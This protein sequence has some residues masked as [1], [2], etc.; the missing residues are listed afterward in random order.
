MTLLADIDHDFIQ[1]KSPKKYDVAYIA[2]LLYKA[3][4]FVVDFQDLKLVKVKHLSDI[5][6]LYFKLS[7]RQIKQFLDLESQVISIVNSH[8]D[9]WFNRRMDE[10][11]IE[12]FY[13]SCISIDK[14]HGRVFKV[15]I[16]RTRQFDLNP[17]KLGYVNVSLQAHH[18]QFNKRSFNIQWQLKDIVFK[19]DALLG[20]D[21]GLGSDSDSVYTEDEMLMGPDPEDLEAMRQE[22]IRK[23]TDKM[24]SLTKFMHLLEENLASLNNGKQVSITDLDNVVVSLNELGME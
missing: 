16:D 21:F 17:E 18:L 4:S 13:D 24:E 14:K 7:L 1:I 11:I 19:P 6:V 8:V 10:S 12:E 22:L 20:L 23:I 5:S 9:D 2:K 3:G 15:R